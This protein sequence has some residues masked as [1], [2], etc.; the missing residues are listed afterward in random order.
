V[1][2]ACGPVR[3]REIGEDGSKAAKPDIYFPADGSRAGVSFGVAERKEAGGEDLGGNANAR[4]PGVVDQQQRE[5][6]ADHTV[7]DEG[8]AG[9][10]CRKG[11]GERRPE[12]EQGTALVAAERKERG[13][14]AESGKT[15]EGS[16]DRRGAGGKVDEAASGR[17]SG[18][19]HNATNR[20]RIVSAHA[21]CGGQAATKEDP[22]PTNWRW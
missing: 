8:A 11:I 12:S 6:G 13:A 19:A 5:S 10:V 7:R 22:Q 18:P 21:A 1:C 20:K 3:L 2:L 17:G 15:I 14:A 16:D 9:H 4:K